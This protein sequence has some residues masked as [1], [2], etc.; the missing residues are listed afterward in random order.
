MDS[1][2]APLADVFFRQVF[3]HFPS[4]R[5]CSHIGKG[6]EQPLRMFIFSEYPFNFGEVGPNKTIEGLRQIKCL[7]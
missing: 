4:K 3:A 2:Q 6:Q 5:M 1:M 7:R